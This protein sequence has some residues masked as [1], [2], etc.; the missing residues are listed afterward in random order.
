[1][2][3]VM[4]VLEAKGAE[5]TLFDLVV[6]VEMSVWWMDLYPTCCRKPIYLFFAGFVRKFAFSMGVSSCIFALVI[7]YCCTGATSALGV[8]EPFINVFS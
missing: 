5:I 3:E 7:E 2:N 6:I 1:M 4:N 8:M